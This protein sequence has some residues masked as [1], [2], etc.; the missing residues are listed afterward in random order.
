MESPILGS[1][2]NRHLMYIKEA[3]KRW[4]VCKIAIE[5]RVGKLDLG[6]VAV[7]V[8][9]SAPHRDA[10]FEAGRFAIDTLKETAPIWKLESYRDGQ[11]WVDPSRS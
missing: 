9:V 5:H 2:A 4:K 1:G 6:D 8:S 10:A 3:R 7:A 11:S